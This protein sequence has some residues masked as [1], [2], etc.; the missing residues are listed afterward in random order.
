[1]MERGA[2]D[3]FDVPVAHHRD[4][5]VKRRYSLPPPRPSQLVPRISNGDRVPQ[6]VN[7]PDPAV[8]QRPRDLAIG[9]VKPDGLDNPD[10][11]R[12]ACPLDDLSSAVCQA[13]RRASYKMSGSAGGGGVGEKDERAIVPTNCAKIP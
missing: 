9:A 7:H 2:F 5:L 1:M 10:R 13:G 3:G 6:E 12:E 8:D 11:A 4:A